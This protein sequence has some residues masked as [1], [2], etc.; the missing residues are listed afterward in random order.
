MERVGCFDLL[1]NPAYWSDKQ[2]ARQRVYYEKGNPWRKPV[3]EDE[4]D[5]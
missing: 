1:Q 2:V 4:D 5:E 3:E